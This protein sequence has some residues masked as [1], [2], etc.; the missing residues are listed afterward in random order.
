MDLAA[1]SGVR[2]A[3]LSEETNLQKV[4]DILTAGTAPISI[5][6]TRNERFISVV[7]R[8]WI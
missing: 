4:A 3:D 2:M 1:A 7:K 6:Y 8:E 5:K